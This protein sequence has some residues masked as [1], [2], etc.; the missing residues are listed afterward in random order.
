MDK[1]SKTQQKNNG[2]QPINAIFFLMKKQFLHI[3]TILGLLLPVQLLM[4]QTNTEWKKQ[5][6]YLA[7]G[8]DADIIFR[9]GDVDNLNFG[10]PAGYN[11]FSGKTSLTHRFPFKPS[12]TDAAGTDRIMVTSG[13]TNSGNT[14]G[15]TSSTRRPD[16]KP[17]ALQLK[18][19]TKNIPVQKVVL[20]IFVDD[21]QPGIFAKNYHVYFDN[22]RIPY[23]EYVINSLS[24][25]GPVGKLITI[26]I[27][28]QYLH[29]FE[30][31][32]LTFFIDDPYTKNGDGFAIDFIQLLINPKKT[33]TCVAKGKA[34][35]YKNGE[36]LPSALIT[37]SNGVQV[38]TEKDG[39]F[40]LTGIT[41][42][43][44]VIN[45]MKTG[46]KPAFKSADVTE[47]DSSAYLLLELRP[48]GIED[49]GALQRILNEKGQIDLYSIQFDVNSD[50]IKPAS[51][52]QLKEFADALNN[53]AQWKVE[54]SG[55]TDSDGD[56]Q[57]N[58]TLSQKRAAAIFEWLKK[59]N[60]PTM[61]IQPVGYGETRPVAANNTAEG[62]ELNRRVEIKIISN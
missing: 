19:E 15:Y 54:I 28:P 10:W 53:N 11:P 41:P 56:A 8:K 16:N 6:F 55:H 27:L 1:E 42:G 50:K 47:N 29:F 37:A 43:L 12:N 14:D 48:G 35:N 2:Q 62:K 40:Y 44:A 23:L 32:E 59:N 5:Q 24:Q 33:S 25:S 7:G 57:A 36:P 3:I 60:V 46:F 9:Y 51:E 52:L 61:N 30:D 38:Y 31:G 26:D 17:V 13:Y 20:Q 58:M 22:E 39:S 4:A 49:A 21:F 34:V 18:W 45:G